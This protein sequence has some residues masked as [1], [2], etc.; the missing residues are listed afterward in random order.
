M[1]ANSHILLSSKR[2]HAI[3]RCCW[4]G[5]LLWSVAWE[6]WL[7]PLRPGG[8]LLVLKALPLLLALPSI[9]QGR[10]YTFQWCSM[11]VLFYFAEAVMRLFDATMA[12]KGCAAVMLVLSVGF[13]VSCLA[14]IRKQRQMAKQ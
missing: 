9:W 10:I 6:W 11:L 3:A 14:F 2:A 8:S 12:S 4:L 13:F 1:A 5:M 7:A